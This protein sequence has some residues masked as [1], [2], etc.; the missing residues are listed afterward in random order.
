MR[1]TI[2]C[3]LLTLSLAGCGAQPLATGAAGSAMMA[4]AKANPFL[5]LAKFEHGPG[6]GVLNKKAALSHLQ[7]KT[8]MGGFLRLVDMGD[9]TLAFYNYE[10]ITVPKKITQIAEALDE[11]AASAEPA[12]ASVLR[13]YKAKLTAPN[14]YLGLADVAF[15]EGPPPATTFWVHAKRHVFA[16]TKDGGN[17]CLAEQRPDIV[18]QFGIVRNGKNVNDGRARK[19]AVEAFMQA[20]PQV[21]DPEVVKFI[22]QR[23]HD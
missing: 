12:L 3:L 9:L 8:K 21:K 4:A 14:P 10:E 19:F 6:G 20:L 13:D 7:A 15:V 23:L 18:Y 16:R 17:L 1:H 22:Q 2:P 11:A 5:G